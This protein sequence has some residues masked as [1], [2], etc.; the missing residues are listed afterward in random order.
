MENEVTRVTQVASARAERKAPE[1]RLYVEARVA[2]PSASPSTVAAAIQAQRLQ[3]DYERALGDYEKL[4]TLEKLSATRP[5]PPFRG[6]TF[7][8]INEKVK[9]SFL[10][11][12]PE[13][14]HHAAASP[15]NPAALSVYAD[16]RAAE[17][18]DGRLYSTLMTTNVE[19]NVFHEERRLLDMD[20]E[21]SAARRARRKGAGRMEGARTEMDER[22]FF[23]KFHERYREAVLS[24]RDELKRPRD[25]KEVEEELKR[26]RVW[27]DARAMGDVQVPDEYRRL[28]GSEMPL[29]ERYV[30]MSGR[31]ADIARECYEH[32]ERNTPQARRL[33]DLYDEDIRLQR[34]NGLGDELA[35]N[36]REKNPSEKDLPQLMEFTKRDF[37]QVVHHDWVEEQYTDVCYSKFVENARMDGHSPARIYDAICEDR[38]SNGIG[39]SKIDQKSVISLSQNVD[40][41][42]INGLDRH[43]ESSSSI[44]QALS[45]PP[46]N[47]GLVS[48][49]KGAGV[50]KG[51]MEAFM[52][53][54][55]NPEAYVVSEGAAR[56]MPVGVLRDDMIR[57]A[58]ALYGQGDVA[59]LDAFLADAGVK[60]NGNEDLGSAFGRAASSLY[61]GGDL[62]GAMCTDAFRK[63]WEKEII[64]SRQKMPVQ[65]PSAVPK[66]KPSL[67]P[68]G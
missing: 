14:D 20:E 39:H 55:E 18:R 13:F 56:S 32:P 54:M 30:R 60:F 52:R 34:V 25:M 9:H 64:A 35:R 38:K 62:Q 50:P 46:G 66:V 12:F 57:T 61:G 40:E 68:R 48:A 36:T 11:A 24:V 1:R 15:G 58:S 37:V 31:K 41:R 65:A 59:K 23:E 19:R 49:M 27:E 28:R 42:L 51:E 53:R 29:L 67:L 6:E 45:V 7:D 10:A 2:P 16:F 21:P 26:V 17:S 3:V 5:V 22:A 43:I 8:S 63:K 4:G 47:A 44:S 33:F